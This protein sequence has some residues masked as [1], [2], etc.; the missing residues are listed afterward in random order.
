MRGFQ[1]IFGDLF[2]GGGENYEN[3][4]E[5]YSREVSSDVTATLKISKSRAQKGGEVSFATRDGRKITV[6]IPAGI[7][8][9]K[10]LRL[11]RQGNACRTCGHPGDLILTIKV[12]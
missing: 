11:A 8:S 2:G 5:D 4:E 7:G 1:D 9:G 12:E 10:K 6:K 3:D